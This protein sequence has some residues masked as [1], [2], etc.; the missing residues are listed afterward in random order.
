[1]RVSMGSVG[2][3]VCGPIHIGRSLPAGNG[4]PARAMKLLCQGYSV[5]KARPATPWAMGRANGGGLCGDPGARRT[6]MQSPDQWA[7]L[8]GH[9]AVVVRLRGAA[10]LVPCAGGLLA[11]CQVVCGEDA[12]TR[13]CLAR[14]VGRRVHAWRLGALTAAAEWG[15]ARGARW[16]ARV[17]AGRCRGDLVAARTLRC[18]RPT[19]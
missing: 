1:M 5:T 11:N 12:P 16:V 8:C 6:T 18:V 7:L 10:P 19:H 17:W 13:M 4:S 9:P 15:R 2:R 14:V 3:V